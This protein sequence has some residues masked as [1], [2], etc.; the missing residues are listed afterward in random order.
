MTTNANND[1]SDINPNQQQPAPPPI[2][3][4]HCNHNHH[5]NSLDRKDLISS[6]CSELRMSTLTRRRRQ[7]AGD[8]QSV[9][10]TGAGTPTTT[11]NGDAPCFGTITPRTR[12]G[13][14]N[15][16]H[17]SRDHSNNSL[18]SSPKPNVLLTNFSISP[19][20]E[21]PR[22]KAASNLRARRFE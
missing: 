7:F 4:N 10:P 17:N 18:M 6:I 21:T 2:T 20:T 16:N 13:F 11:T 8:I 9:D 22:F 14:E 3:T 15:M 5:Y 1:P 19:Y 12:G